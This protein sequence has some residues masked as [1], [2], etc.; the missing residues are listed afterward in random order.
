VTSRRNLLL[1]AAAAGLAA[2][3]GGTPQEHTRGIVLLIDTSGTYAKQIDKVKHI[4]GAILLKLEPHDSVA[5]ARIDT[6][7]FTE[8][9]ILGRT[10]LPDSE[11]AANQEKTIFNGKILKSL[12]SEEPSAYTDITGGLLEAIEYL[13]EKDTA[14]KQILIFSDMEEDLKPGMV[15][16]PVPLNLKGMDV[17][18]LNVTKLRTDNV[19]PRKYLGRLAAWKERVEK[20]GGHWRV[21]NDID[22]LEGLL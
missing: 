17:I 6:A 13:N 16:D 10:T 20:G 12:A 14:R 15:R 19:D 7:S 4:I 3:A 9:N 11:G 8:K 21:I 22:H 1:L 18:A 2:C 5:V